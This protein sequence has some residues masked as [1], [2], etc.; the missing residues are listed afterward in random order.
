MAAPG[1]D[2][3]AL[4]KQNRRRTGWLFATFLTLFAALGFGADLW[5]GT[6][7]LQNGHLSGL[8]ILTAVAL[9]YG[10]IHATV[11][12]YG[13]ASL[14]LMSVHVPRSVPQ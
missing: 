7:T 14:V 6:L 4:E 3:F 11:S 5:L 13:G 9:I 1:S 8:P 12:Y 2:F 10:I